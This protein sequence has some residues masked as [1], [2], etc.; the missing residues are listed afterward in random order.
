[1]ENCLNII[2][3]NWNGSDYTIDCLNSII[4]NSLK[5]INVIIVDN[6]SNKNDIENLESFC[7]RT[8]ENFEVFEED[9]IDN[10]RI[11]IEDFYHRKNAKEFKVV[12]IRNKE[13]LGFAKGNNVALKYLYVNGQ[14]MAMLLNNDTVIM[15]DSLKKIVE[16]SYC[17]PEIVAITPQIRYFEPNNVVWNCGGFISW[18]GHQTYLYGGE[19]VGNV[20]K[21]GYRLVD[22]VTG[23]ALFL[24]L[25]ET[26][27]LSERFYFGEEDLELCLRLKKEH[28]QIAVL[29]DSII[30]HKVGGTHKKIEKRNIGKMIMFYTVRLANLRSYYNPCHYFFI[31]LAYVL[32]SINNICIRNGYTLL[33][34]LKMWRKIFVLLYRYKKFDKTL[35]F[36]VINIKL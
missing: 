33:T 29:F 22:Y 27:F 10:C 18:L 11:K 12:L 4:L 19:K 15:K 6:N 14:M 26:N 34:Y 17:H 16:F 2:I 32:G 36:E 23:C 30:F 20:P 9:D 8:F 3:L 35:F 31:L 5:N 1:M 25:Q 21:L 7:F 13:N 24:K 28:K